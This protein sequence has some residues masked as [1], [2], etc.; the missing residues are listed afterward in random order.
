[1]TISP[2][3]NVIPDSRYPL[4]ILASGVDSLVLAI[5]VIWEDETFFDY[6]H[7]MK[8]M[9][10]EEDTDI[11]VTLGDREGVAPLLLSVRP[12]GSDGYEW[13]LQGSDYTLKIGKWLEPKSRP[14][15]MAQIHSEALWSLGPEPA[16]DV[17]LSLLAVSGAQIQK[18]KPSRVDLCVDYL[19]PERQWS[20]NLV[21]YS[22]TRAAKCTPHYR[23]K[24]LTGITIGDGSKVS[25]R[26]YDKPL[27]INQKSK[28][29]W[30]YEVWGI[31]A[32]P[33]GKRIIRVEGQFRREAIKT[34][35]IDSAADLFG[36]LDNLWAYFT[37]KWLKFA[38]NPEKHQ[39][40]RKTLP[41][42]RTI[43]NGF[44]GVQNAEPL[45][46]CQ[47]LQTKKKQLAAQAYGTVNSFL[48]IEQEERGMPL[49]HDTTMK[50]A[51][52]S[53]GHYFEQNGKN[54]FALEI[55]TLNKRA[56]YHKAKAK[57]IEVKRRRQ[58]LGFPCNLP[59]D[60]VEEIK[61]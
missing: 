56:K 49:G 25:A 7:E 29:F 24:V 3:S 23:H 12:F 36:C 61:K 43:Q 52:D 26:L 11:A 44:F 4:K 21:K 30:M 45:I 41:F 58:E 40:S 15:I 1:M 14:S 35:G 57:M 18:V 37:R 27:E 48:A 5:D 50:E 47:S 54:D 19:M 10:K 28:K 31:E 22:V 60:L 17:L 2:P 39:L 38:N 33:E 55:D 51:L 8:A 13:L 20:P 34:L 9:A 59:E 53:L 42:W 16:L 6:L 46:R 32:V